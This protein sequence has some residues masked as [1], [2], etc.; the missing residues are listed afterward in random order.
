MTTFVS[1]NLMHTACLYPSRHAIIAYHFR[2]IDIS[3]Q[4]MQAKHFPQ[5]AEIKKKLKQKKVN[6]FIRYSTQLC[7]HVNKHLF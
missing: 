3:M 5:C 7:L 2:N 1:I 4:F 6:Y